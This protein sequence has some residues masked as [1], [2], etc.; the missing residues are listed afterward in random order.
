[1][2]RTKMTEINDLFPVALD[3]IA[4]ILSFK[5][6]I[7]CYLDEALQN[8]ST[9]PTHSRWQRMRERIDRE[10]VFFNT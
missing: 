1:M 7:S 4:I 10:T 6:T 9:H 8:S 2:N 5:I 3:L